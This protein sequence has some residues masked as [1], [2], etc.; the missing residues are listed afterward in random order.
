MLF[1][2]FSDNDFSKLLTY[3]NEQI[4]VTQLIVDTCKKFHFDGIVLE[5]WSQLAARVSDQ[6]LMDF[7]TL[8]GNRNKNTFQ[9]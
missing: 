5:L 7:V 2:K 4:F 3:E 1:D 9:S 6:N 8:I